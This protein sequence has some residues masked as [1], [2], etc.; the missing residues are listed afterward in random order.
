LGALSVLII[1]A[2]LLILYG[3]RLPDRW[4]TVVP[5]WL[6]AIALVLW[7][8]LRFQAERPMSLWEWQAPLELGTAFGFKLVGW[9]WLSG[10]GICLLAFTAVALPGWR[11]RPGF[12]DPRHWSLLTAALA[13]LVVLSDTWIS[14]LAAWALMTAFLGL[15]A[16]ATSSGSAKAWSVGI[17]STLFLM[18]ASLLNG[19]DS[20]NIALRGQPLNAQAQLLVVLAAA[21]QLAVYPF[22]LW[23]VPETRRSPGRH[24]IIHLV[25]GLAALHLLGVFDLTLLS[26]QAWAPLSIVALLGSALVA[27]SD[28]NRDRAWIYVLIN[29]GVWAVLILGLTRLPAPVGAIYPLAVLALGGALWGIARVNPYRSR[30][31]VPY[32]LAAALFLGLPFTPGFVSNLVLG[33]LAGSVFGLPGW[34][35]VLLAQ[36][37]LVAAMFRPTSPQV[38]DDVDQPNGTSRFVTVA[39]VMAAILTIWWGVFPANLANLAGYAPSDAFGGLLAQFQ[40]AGWAGWMTLLLP[41]VLGLLIG[42]FDERLFGALRG[43]QMNLAHIAGLGWL[44]DGLGR[45]FSVVNTTIGSLSDLLDGA[46]Q[47][48]WVLLAA[49]IA[50]ILLVA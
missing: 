40:Q 47:F 10:F 38:A 44:Y 32:L 3:R 39:L 17:L 9:V 30:W 48:G 43:W 2:G 4:R 11:W 34:I 13:L 42:L 37:M 29:R 41:I 25:P 20:L 45:V 49:L 16:A 6:T 18:G 23:L 7:I 46:G 36:I 35:L 5:A 22:H 31:S 33:Q 8:F 27:W 19:V 24:L 50:W 21:L 15:A 12:V 14:L 1:G 26:S 28:P